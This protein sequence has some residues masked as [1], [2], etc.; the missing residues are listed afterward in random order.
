MDVLAL[1]ENQRN[2]ENR[3]RYTDNSRGARSAQMILVFSKKKNSEITCISDQS[4][5]LNPK[6]L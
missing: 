6:T 1:R 4:I 3:Y 2:A 5:L